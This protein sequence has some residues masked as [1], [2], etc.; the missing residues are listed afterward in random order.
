MAC[1]PKTVHLKN[2]L[3]LFFTR[4]LTMSDRPRSVE[5]SFGRSQ[6]SVVAIRV[7]EIPTRYRVL[8]HNLILLRQSARATSPAPAI[9]C[10]GHT[11]GWT[12]P[13]I[14]RYDSAPTTR[15]T[16]AERNAI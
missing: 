15:T 3:F 12:L 8:E 1:L 9:F 7:E 5:I 10:S 4:Q 16:E 14:S 6:S 2:P 11:I 13:T